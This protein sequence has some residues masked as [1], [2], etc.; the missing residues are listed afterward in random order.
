MV[1]WQAGSCICSFN[2]RHHPSTHD[3]LNPEPVCAKQDMCVSGK[4]GLA[5]RVAGI[6]SHRQSSP[7]IFYL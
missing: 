5:K 7:R 6:V 2:D 4:L 3:Y 1:L